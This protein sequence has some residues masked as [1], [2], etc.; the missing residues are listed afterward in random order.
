LPTPTRTTIATL[1]LGLAAALLAGC[2]SD[3]GVATSPTSPPAAPAAASGTFPVEITTAAGT[4]TVAARPVRIVSLAPTA[5]EMLFAIGAGEQVVAVDDQ[6]N[7]PPEAPRTDLSGFTP[8]LEA[9]VGNRPDLVVVTDSAR[10][11]A[12]GLEQFD[13]PTAVLPAA[14]EFED[15]YAQLEQLGAATGHVAEAAGLVAR[16]QSDIAALAAEVPKRGEPLTYYHELDP[17]FFTATS[18]TFIGAVYE[19]A[20]LR[21]IADAAGGAGDYP[22]LSSEAI[23]RADP[24]LIFLADTKCCQQTADSVATRPGWST[25]SAVRSGSVVALD[26]DVASRWGPRVV[27]LLRQVIDAVK[28]VPQPAAVAA[29]AG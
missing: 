11:V 13:I 21:N 26:D 17:T 16:M 2:G 20:G 12:G 19:V 28:A 15:T 8:N 7:F 3:E 25:I 10:E 6:S 18:K 9:I 23:V 29:G 22:Q 5:T 14:V 27:D 24:D 1:S 4:F